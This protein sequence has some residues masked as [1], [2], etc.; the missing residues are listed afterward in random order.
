MLIGAEIERGRAM[1]QRKH[2]LPPF[3]S[4]IVSEQ[5]YFRWLA[6]KAVAHVRRDRKRFANDAIGAAYRQAIHEAVVASGGRDD[7]TGEEL[8]W[9]LLSKY[10]NAE[11]QE[12]RHHYKAGFALLPT[13]DHVEASAS[14]AVFKVCAWRTNDAKSD[15]SIDGFIA[16]CARVLI[17]AGYRVEPPEQERAA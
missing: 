10:A 13:V 1:S 11:S 3:L 15:L 16:L 7:Y 17:H 14:A 2:Q 12:G 9:T 5:V 8:D 6:R 4:G